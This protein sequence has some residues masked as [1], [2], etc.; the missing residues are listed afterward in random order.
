MFHDWWQRND[1]MPLNRSSNGTKFWQWSFTNVSRVSPLSPLTPIHPHVAISAFSINKFRDPLVDCS[2]IT[3]RRHRVSLSWILFVYHCR[4]MQW[5]WL[6]TYRLLLLIFIYILSLIIILY[7]LGYLKI[8]S[9]PSHIK[10][11]WNYE[12]R[13]I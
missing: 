3:L 8:L 9:L 1:K 7:K 2:F 5:F 11:R 12:I 10:F 13:Y 6:L 4:I